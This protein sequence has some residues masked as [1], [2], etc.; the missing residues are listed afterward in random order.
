VGTDAISLLRKAP[1]VTVD[2]NDNISVLGRYGEL[3][4]VDGKRLPLAGD[5]LSNYLQSLPAERI[6]R[7][8]IITN[9]GARYEAE[10][11]AGIIDIRLKR[12]KSHGSNGTANASYSKGRHYM[13]NLGISGNYR[14]SKLNVFGNLGY[15][16][17]KG[18][19][20]I[21]FL[22]KLGEISLNEIDE[23]VNY[24]NNTNYRIGTDFFLAEKH[25]LGFLISGNVNDNMS[26]NENRIEI[27]DQGEL[28][29][30]DSLLLSNNDEEGSRIDNQYNLNYRYDDRKNG[31]SVNV[32]LDYGAFDNKKNRD[33]PNSYFDPEGINLLSESNY[34]FDTPTEIQIYTFKLDYEQKLLGGQLGLGTKLAR[35]ESHNE[36]YIFK[37]NNEGELVRN[38]IRSNIYDYDEN[39]YAG[40]VSYARPINKKWNFTAGLRLEQTDAEG[41]TEVFDPISYEPPFDRNYLSWFP[42]AGLTWQVKPMHTLALNYGR[43]INRPDYNILNPIESQ[44][45]ELSFWNGNPRLEPEIVNNIELGYTMNYRYNLKIGYSKTLDQITRLIEPS[46]VDSLATAVQWDNLDDRTVY[47]ANLSLPIGIKKWW[48]AYFNLSASYIDNQFNNGDGGV[49][50]LQVFSYTIFQQHTFTLPAGFKGE[51]S[52]YFSGPGIWGGVF[53]YNETWSLDLGIQKRFM[54]DR[55]NVKL[56]ASDIFYESGWNGSSEFDG[57]TSE[58]NGAWDSR[59]VTLSASL[60][61]GNQN[62]KSRKRKTGIE[63]EAKRVKDGD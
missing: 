11:N 43:R 55:L 6:D 2:N 17:R 13:Y 16:E 63:D 25:T 59:R 27:G 47:S 29:L 9:P 3:L 15:S 10:G 26:N 30:V 57:L 61:F 12:D 60:S 31:R 48:Q 1:G 49:V 56:S 42:S 28:I 8:D 36:F 24:N 41:V 5:D 62:V 39:V 50:D 35:V 40:Y 33:Q 44:T 54:Q 7:I 22:S 51:V 34:F 23:T 46:D 4:Y 58:G 19:H 52:G 21:Y 53:E 38:D 18:Y 37:E 45:S 14:N 32:D 20:D